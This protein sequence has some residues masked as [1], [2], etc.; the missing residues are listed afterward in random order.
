MAKLVSPKAELA[1]LRGMCSKN[2]AIAGSLLAQTD[3]TYFYHDESKELYKAIRKHVVKVGHPPSYQDILEDLRISE[4]A[5]D[6]F[7]LSRRSIVSSE[8]IDTAVS[9]LN[10]YRQ[11]RGLLEIADHI[12]TTLKKSRIDTDDLLMNVTEAITSVKTRKSMEDT[13][14][15]FGRNNSSRELVKDLI[16]GDNTENVIPTGLKTFDERNGGLLRGALF[17]IGGNS[18]AGKTLV[19]NA[20]CMNMAMLGYS[21]LYVPLEMSKREMAAR[22]LSRISGI[23][24]LKIILN[25]LTEREQAYVTRAYRRF[26]RKMKRL[27][28]RYTMFRPKEDMTLEE[29]YS[30]SATY[31]CDVKCVDYLGLTAGMDGDDQ[32]RA[33]GNAARYGKIE[34]ENSNSVNILLVQVSDEGKIRY[35]GKIKEDSSNAW[36]F[37]ATQETKEQGILK[38][39]QIKSRN[40][41]H[42]PFT[43]K[44]NYST[45]DVGDLPPDEVIETSQ[46]KSSS[47]TPPNLAPDV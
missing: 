25:K 1:V 27:G 26:V 9:T 47:S 45:M 4:E 3:E 24:L 15:H 37:T 33:L 20:I 6:H 5:R 38:V 34:A 13:I 28:G 10:R 11:T 32:W 12:N 44:V 46:K 31:N 40:Q 18:G 22:M 21:V 39:N 14:V 41:D 7:R 36:V 8:D 23:D 16:Y 30:A 35:S 42:F 43:V 29:I 2:K 17:T 19:A